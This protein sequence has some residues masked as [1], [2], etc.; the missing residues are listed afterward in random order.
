VV[1]TVCARGHFARACLI[2]SRGRVEKVVQVKYKLLFHVPLIKEKLGFDETLGGREQA[3][4][5]EKVD[6]FAC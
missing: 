2:P 3:Q 5:E 1:E 6:F 4:V